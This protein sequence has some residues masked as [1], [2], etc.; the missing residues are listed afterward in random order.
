MHRDQ[1]SRALGVMIVVNARSQAPRSL[2]PHGVFVRLKARQRMTIAVDI[3]ASQCGDGSQVPIPSAALIKAGC[4]AFELRPDASVDLFTS[5]DVIVAI[6][7]LA[8]S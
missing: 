8:A 5:L 2:I 1:C 3:H 6:V 4:S 7:K